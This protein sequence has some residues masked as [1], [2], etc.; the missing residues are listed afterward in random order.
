[1]WDNSKACIVWWG[2]VKERDQMEEPGIGGSIILKWV[3]RTERGV[4][5]VDWFILAHG[6]GKWPGCCEYG[7]EPSGS[8]KCGEF[9]DQLRKHTI[10]RRALLRQFTYISESIRTQA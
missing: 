2:K 4:E 7:D 10:L 9:P 3:D 8:T 6:R 5:I 1:M